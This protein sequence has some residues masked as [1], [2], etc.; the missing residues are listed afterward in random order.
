[1]KIFKPIIF[2]A[3][4][5]L[6]GTSC[7]K[8]LDVKPKGIIIAET[9]NDYEGLL[10]RDR[11]LMNPFGLS[12]SIIKVTDDLTQPEFSTQTNT[13]AE[14]NLYFWREY[15][16]NTADKGPDVWAEF[17]NVIANM[18]AITEGVLSATDGSE[19]KKKQIYAEAMV[20]KSFIYYQLLSFFSPAY[21]KASA[22][23]DYGVPYITS[24][25][26]SQAAP[27]RP[28]LQESYDHMITDVVAVIPD[29]PETNVN[30]ARVTKNVAYAMLARIYMSMRDY[31]NAEKYADIV[32]NS[33]HATI[34]D[35]NDYI[36]SNLPLTN[37]SP[38]ELFVRYSNNLAFTYSK[39]LLSK[40]NINKDLRIQFFAALQGNG[41]Y[42]F[43]STPYNPNR[44]ITYAEVYLDKAECLAR[45]GDIEGALEIVN[46]NIRKNRFRSADY[47]LLTATSKEEA[48]TAVL[49]ERRRELAFK[50][51]RWSDM[52]R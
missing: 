51:I 39:N 29:L 48:I 24:T 17:Y 37:S 6:F 4:P 1:M 34:L 33:G 43:G 15:I 41:S 13:S 9:V 42:Q 19:Q 2:L 52:K 20:N 45:K 31:T 46:T 47:T 35:Y 11:N 49:Q 38:E 23:T 25:D 50:G 16:N 22:A 3:I 8:F 27:T 26:V 14:V 12:N 21:E 7:K 28:S 30:I 18:N 40:Y 36:G 44:G 5:L 32:L 10:T